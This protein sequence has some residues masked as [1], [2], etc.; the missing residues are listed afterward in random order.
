MK[1]LVF[2][3][4]LGVVFSGAATVTYA[5][6]GAIVSVNP[7]LCM[8]VKGVVSDGANVQ[9]QN[10]G[11]LGQPDIHGSWY[12]VGGN[13]CLFKPS[14][15]TWYCIDYDGGP[16]NPGDSKDAKVTKRA[17][18]KGNQY[19]SYEPDNKFHGHSGQC[20][21]VNALQVGGPGQIK[22]S[23]CQAWKTYQKWTF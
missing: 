20:L 7:L 15:F 16:P 8:A 13:V 19:W 18:W 11:A 3:M 9:L 6:P 2:P 10:C 17:G 22:V 1:K 21:D 23:A 14:D 4:L 5:A 12:N